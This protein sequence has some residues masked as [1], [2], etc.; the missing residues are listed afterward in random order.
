MPGSRLL[1]GGFTAIQQAI[2]TPVGR[3]EGA[4]YLQH[5][6]EDVVSEGLVGLMIGRNDVQGVTVA[7][8]GKSHF[9]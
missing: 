1:D 7:A 9:Q 3:T 8:L 2:G 6:V 4:E 5:F